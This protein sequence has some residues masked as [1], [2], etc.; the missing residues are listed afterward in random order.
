MTARVRKKAEEPECAKATHTENTFRPSYPSPHGC[1]APR[2][3][4][5]PSNNTASEPATDSAGDNVTAEE[6]PSGACQ[7]VALDIRQSATGERHLVET[8]PPYV[9]AVDHRLLGH[10]AVHAA[11]FVVAIGSYQAVILRLRS[12]EVKREASWDCSA[13]KCIRQLQAAAFLNL[14][15]CYLK[16]EQWTQAVNAAT[17]V[18]QGEQSPPNPRD[19][20]LV[21][22]RHAKTLFHRAQADMRGL[23]NATR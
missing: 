18:I 9:K 20:V 15:L 22:G 5:E 4:A 14:S 3:V 16:T 19:N 17:Y 7:G 13:W 8:D 1:T 23:G 21:H 12:L 10:K 11:K 6:Y 2:R